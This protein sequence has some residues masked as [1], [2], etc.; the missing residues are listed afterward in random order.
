MRLD[1]YL[2]EYKGKNVRQVGLSKEEWD[3]VWQLADIARINTTLTPELV[4]DVRVVL[5]SL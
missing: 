2:R 3:N 4:D 1:S 5:H